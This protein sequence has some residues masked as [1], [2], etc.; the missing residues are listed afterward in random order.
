MSDEPTPKITLGRKEFAV[1]EYVVRDIKKL[2]PKM[3][4]AGKVDYTAMAEPDLEVIFAVLF[5]AV[6]RKDP[7]SPEATLITQDEFDDLP[8]RVEEIAAAMSVIAKQ[9]GLT[10]SGGASAAAPAGPSDGTTS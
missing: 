6:S 1:P 3:V 10:K 9:A 8:I 2:L 7:E 4:L 5:S